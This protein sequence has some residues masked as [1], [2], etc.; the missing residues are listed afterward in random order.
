MRG[1][2]RLGLGWLCATRRAARH[3]RPNWLTV[4]AL[5]LNVLVLA[6]FVAVFLRR[7]AG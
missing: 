5:A 1:A 6:A 3:C 7:Y 4:A 2:H